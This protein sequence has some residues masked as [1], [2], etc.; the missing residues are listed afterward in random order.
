MDIIKLGSSTVLRFETA[1]PPPPLSSLA[2]DETMINDDSNSSVD[3]PRPAKRAKHNE[4]EI[5]EVDDGEVEVIATTLTD[6]EI[7]AVWKLGN[8]Y[9]RAARKLGYVTHVMLPDKSAW[10]PFEQHPWKRIRRDY[11]LAKELA[12]AKRRPFAPPS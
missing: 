8:C 12:E 7:D 11:Q 4:Q 9:V 6:E 5:E 2:L 3:L 10:V 1:P